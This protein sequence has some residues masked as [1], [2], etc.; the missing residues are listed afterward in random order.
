MN[1]GDIDCAIR[2]GY[3]EN[4]QDVREERTWPITKSSD[5]DKNNRFYKQ[6]KQT[7]R[8]NNE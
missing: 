6:V 2:T 1:P 8:L 3:P 7:E 5:M 4:N